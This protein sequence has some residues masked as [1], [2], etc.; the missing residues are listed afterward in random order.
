MA[1]WVSF[2]KQPAGIS[3][4]ALVVPAGATVLLRPSAPMSACQ[5]A[6]LSEDLAAASGRTGVKFVVLADAAWQAVVIGT[7][8]KPIGVDVLGMPIFPEEQVPLASQSPSA[9]NGDAD[10]QLTPCPFLP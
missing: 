4:D 10:P 9:Q 7:P 1:D 6:Q 3:M 5:C 8:A 2:F